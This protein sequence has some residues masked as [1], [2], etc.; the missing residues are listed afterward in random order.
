M[1]ESTRSA[2]L[3]NTIFETLRDEVLRSHPW[4]FA[5]KRVILSPNSTTPEF[6]WLYTFDLPS[7][8]LRVWEVYTDDIEYAIEADRVMVSN[9]TE[10]D[11]VYIYR[12]TDPSQWD[13]M[14]AEALAWRLAMDLS[15]ALTQSIS[16]GQECERKYK[17]QMALAR[18]VDGTEGVLRRLIADDWT[19]SRLQGQ[20]EWRGIEY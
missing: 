6:D 4:N 2:V 7:D 20:D 18:S 19:T 14:F 17:E 8:L 12:N 3:A 11:V 1:S 10:M 5:I 16:L 9:E 15:Y 13:T